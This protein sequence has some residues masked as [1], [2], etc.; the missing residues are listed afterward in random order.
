MS[1]ILF[2]GNQRKLIPIFLFINLLEG[3]ISQFLHGEKG[4]FT[5]AGSERVN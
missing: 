3:R 5:F 4:F 2:S 1:I